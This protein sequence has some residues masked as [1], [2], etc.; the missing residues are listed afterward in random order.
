[1][2]AGRRRTGHRRGL[3]R[4]ASTSVPDDNGG[5]G[6]LQGREGEGMDSIDVQ[7]ARQL[8]EGAR[9]GSAAPAVGGIMGRPQ[10]GMGEPQGALGGPLGSSMQGESKTGDQRKEAAAT[11]FPSVQRRLGLWGA[12]QQPLWQQYSQQHH[13]HQYPQQQQQQPH[14]HQHPQQQQQ[15]QQQE[16]HQEEEQEGQQ[17]TQN[18]AFEGLELPLLPQPQPAPPPRGR[19][20]GMQASWG[21]AQR[22]ALSAGSWLWASMTTAGKQGSGGAVWGGGVD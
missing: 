3:G 9:L 4:S 19:L 18:P 11:L 14:H 22:A 17:W 1:M 10:G 12:E 2:Q 5:P 16:A 6:G 21:A 7:Q 8:L 15:Q 20:Q 13:H